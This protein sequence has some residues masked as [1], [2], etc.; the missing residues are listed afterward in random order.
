MS[1]AYKITE[2][3]MVLAVEILVRDGFLTDE[4]GRSHTSN[5]VAA[6]AACGRYIEASRAKGEGRSPQDVQ[7]VI[8]IAYFE[9]Y[10]EAVTRKL[11]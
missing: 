3:G 4:P 7:D 9:A 11:N 6:K 10:L 5:L 8:V 2:A 1:E